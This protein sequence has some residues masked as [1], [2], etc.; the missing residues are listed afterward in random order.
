MKF[1]MVGMAI[2]AEKP[3]VSAA[4]FT[5]HFGFAV[6]VDL[7]WYVNTQHTDHPALSLDF[8]QRDHP[9]WPAA[10]RGKTVVGTLLAFLVADVDAEY[11]RLGDEGLEVVLPPV[12]EPWG[13]RRF[14]V[15]GPDGLLVEV[16]QQVAPDPQ[17]LADNGFGA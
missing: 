14:Q 4:W 6:G 5:E 15:A 2:A 16:L 8:V 9:S 12:T 11:A 3:A 7:G 10:T 17:W 1:T 13:Q